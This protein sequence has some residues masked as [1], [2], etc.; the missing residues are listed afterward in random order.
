[1]GLKKVFMK[2][3]YV[4]L[5]SLLFFFSYEA[6]SASPALPSSVALYEYPWSQWSRTHTPYHKYRVLSACGWTALGVGS[7]TTVLGSMLCAFAGEGTN[8]PGAMLA[9]PI[10]GGTLTVASIPTLVFAYKNRRKALAIGA[11]N[12]IIHTPMQME[13]QPALAVRF[14]F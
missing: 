14:C 5:F 1:M 11:T 6:K 7:V 13:Q 8:T 9:I 4:L 3:L 10:V 2:P 12:Q